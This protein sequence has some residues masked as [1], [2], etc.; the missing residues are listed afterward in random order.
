[1]TTQLLFYAQA[2]PVSSERHRDLFVK[3][4]NQ[5][6]FAANV[7]AVPLMGVEFR[8][9]ALE[10]PIVFAGE[11]E[12]L[13]PV[14]VLGIAR[15][16]NACIDAHGHWQ[17]RYIPAFVRRYP[18][19]FAS[20]DDGKTFTL[21]IDE[22]F[23]GCNREGRGERLFDAD[24]ERTAYLRNVLGFVTEYQAQFQRTRAFAGR[25]R[26]LGLLEPM[27]AQFRLPSGEP[28]SLTGFQ[29][30]NRERLKAL[31]PTV[32]AALAQS[33]ELELI[34]LQLQSMQCFGN[35]AERAGAPAPVAANE[36]PAMGLGPDGNLH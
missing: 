20:S 9:A 22:D 7:N 18:F 8:A 25:L 15:D 26:D 36:A 32:L 11:G 14:A 6:G 12:A 24:G 23:A 4:G 28:G 29:A 27:T 31:D 1:M 19:V 2:L 17:G 30:V 33:D 34:Y 21:C 35:L 13:S 5:Y 10:Y 16:R 3:A